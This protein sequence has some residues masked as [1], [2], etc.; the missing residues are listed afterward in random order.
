MHTDKA[1][2]SIGLY[3]GFG[4]FTIGY[5]RKLGQ[6]EKPGQSFSLNWM[7]SYYGLEFSYTN[8]A[9]DMVQ[10]IQSSTEVRLLAVNGYFAFNCKRFSYSS[11]YKGKLIQK[12]SAGSV[13]LAAKYLYGNFL[14]VG[15]EEY[16]MYMMHRNEKKACWE[17]AR[18]VYH[19]CIGRSADKMQ[20]DC[21]VLVKKTYLCGKQD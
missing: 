10:P 4:P 13:M 8:M 3:A 5:S 21:S 1:P 2:A 11:A 9:D 18:G 15:M 14:L 17:T 20:T 16:P 7:A 19:F 6:K 12:R